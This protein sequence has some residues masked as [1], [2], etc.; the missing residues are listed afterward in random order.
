MGQYFERL[1]TADEVVQ[2]T[3]FAIAGISVERRRHERA[4]ALE[5][6]GSQELVGRFDDQIGRLGL[7]ARWLARYRRR[8]KCCKKPGWELRTLT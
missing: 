1:F 3:E 7:T 6:A 2:R 4:R 5:F 8:E